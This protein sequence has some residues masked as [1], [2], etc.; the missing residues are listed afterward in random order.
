M[1]PKMVIHLIKIGFG[2]VHSYYSR[3]IRDISTGTSKQ[4]GLEYD[5]KV[6]RKILQT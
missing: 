1:L 2:D 3:K 5:S 6:I 4:E